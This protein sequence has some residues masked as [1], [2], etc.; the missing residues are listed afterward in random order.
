MTSNGII[1]ALNKL[2]PVET[3]EETPA[4]ETLTATAPGF[5]MGDMGGDV[6]V[7][8]TLNEDGT[9]A[10]LTV[11]VANQTPGIGDK[12]ADEAW[13]GQFIGKKGPF[14]AGEGVDVITGS[15]M[16]SNGIIDALNKLFPAEAQ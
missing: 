3:V 14:V 16:T 9:I 11:D 10:T 6:T 15:T 2:F 13:L 12:C 5:A 7:A 8:V 1:D 4:V